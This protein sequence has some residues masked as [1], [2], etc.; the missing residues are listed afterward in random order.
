VVDARPWSPAAAASLHRS[1]DD[2]VTDLEV[3]IAYQDDVIASL[4]QV[5]RE[6]ADRVVHLER[7]LAELRRSSTGA[8]LGPP[9]EP[10]PH[11]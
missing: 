9:D 3:R 7:E 1:A 2:R 11:Y 4:D 6:F 8:P 5:V 10:P